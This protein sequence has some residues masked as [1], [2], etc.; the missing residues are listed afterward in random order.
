MDENVRLKNN[1]KQLNENNTYSIY[2]SVSSEGKEDTHN[3]DNEIKTLN[4]DY[5]D[6]KTCI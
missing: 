4:K 6:F 1:A 3:L 2:Y 5:T